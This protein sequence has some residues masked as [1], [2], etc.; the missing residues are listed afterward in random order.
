MYSPGAY[1]SKDNP[2]PSMTMGGYVSTVDQ[3]GKARSDEIDRQLEEDCQQFK[4]ELEIL[5][6]GSSS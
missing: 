4:K 2:P 3:A 1:L 5:V 6:L